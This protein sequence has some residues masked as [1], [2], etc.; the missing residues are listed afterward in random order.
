MNAG[1]RDWLPAALTI[2]GLCFGT[3]AAIQEFRLQRLAHS[4]AAA[5]VNGQPIAQDDVER[6]LAALGADRRAALTRAD[7]DKVLER[8]IEDELLAQR[9]VALGLA[10]NDPN[11]RKVLIRGLIDSLVA[12]APPPAE[13]DLRRYFDANA[14]IFRG[15]DLI[16]VAPAEGVVKGLPSTPMTIEKLK[17][18]VGETAETLRDVP[19]GG[20]AG[21]FRFAGQEFRLRVVSRSGGARATFDAS[22]DAVLARYVVERDGRRVRAYLDG[23]KRSAKIERVE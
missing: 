5:F 1:W 17:D 11:A 8:L 16:A 18:Y 3:I 7:R 10:A 22:R 23:L 12:A 19:V 2:A 6:A 9:A 20:A 15:A 13:D 21:P 14:N 4:D